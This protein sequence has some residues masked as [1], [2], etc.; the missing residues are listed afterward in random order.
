MKMYTLIGKEIIYTDSIDEWQ[1][2]QDNLDATAE[3]T[4]TIA[5]NTYEIKGESILVSTVFLGV[6][7][8]HGE[9]VPVLFETMVFGGKY[10]DFQRRY[11]TYDE[12]IEGHNNICELV[13]EVSIKRDSQINGL[14]I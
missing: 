3:N 12:A 6:D 11:C 10:N 9:G 8:R 7:H 4:N 13:D 2:C 14:G 5:K 1:D